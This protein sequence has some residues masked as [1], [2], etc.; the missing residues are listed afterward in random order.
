M[1]KVYRWRF[2]SIFVTGHLDSEIRSI[3]ILEIWLRLSLFC[4]DIP[5]HRQ[6]DQFLE[7]CCGIWSMLKVYRERFL[8][9]LGSGKVTQKLKGLMFSKFH[10]VWRDVGG[11]PRII[12]KMIDFWKI[13]LDSSQSWN[14]VDYGFWVYLALVTWLMPW[15]IGKMTDFWRLVFSSIISLLATRC[16]TLITVRE[17]HWLLRVIW[18]FSE[19]MT[20]Y[21][22]VFRMFV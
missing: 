20:E 9:I 2:L 7:K 14:C 13:V 11:T 18:S 10:C 5:N 8:S 21:E 12:K 17:N 6:N 16:D 1:L 3:Y 4:M 19:S 15:I 22:S